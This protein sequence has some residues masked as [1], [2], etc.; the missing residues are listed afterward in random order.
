ME[1]NDKKCGIHGQIQTRGRTFVGVVA[2][3][4]AQHTATVEWERRKDVP[5]YERYETLRSKIAVHNPECIN[6]TKG[7]KVVVKECRPLSK[8]KNFVIIEKHGK[9]IEY[10]AKE[11]QEDTGKVKG[12]EK[13]AA[14]EP[15]KEE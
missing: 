2:Q 11:E 8:T 12:K 13:E 14:P 5:K 10:L 15:E 9:D 7:D 1:C 4:K 3:A 6:A